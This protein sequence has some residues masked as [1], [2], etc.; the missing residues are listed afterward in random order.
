MIQVRRYQ[1]DQ[2]LAGEILARAKDTLT[3]RPQ[4]VIGHSLGSIIAYEVLCTLPDHGVRTLITLGSPLAFRSIR[5]R[6][7]N[8]SCSRMSQLPPGVTHWVNLYDPHDSVAC[9]GGL[10]PYW[11]DVVDRAVNN[12]DQPHAIKRYLGKKETGEAVMSGLMAS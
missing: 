11:T 5:S 3:P 9:A 2:D 10:N 7:R 4:V 1:R 6:L 12:G 8:H